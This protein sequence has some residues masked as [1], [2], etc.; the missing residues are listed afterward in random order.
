MAEVIKC[1]P[2]GLKQAAPAPKNRQVVALRARR[3]LKMTSPGFATENILPCDHANRRAA[4]GRAGQRDA[5]TTGC[6]KSRPENGNIASRT[7]GSSVVVALLIEV[8]RSAGIKSVWGISLHAD[9]TKSSRPRQSQATKLGTAQQRAPTQCP[10]GRC[11][12]RRP[13]FAKEAMSTRVKIL[14]H[15]ESS[16]THKPPS[17]RARMR[18]VFIF[19]EKSPAVHDD[20]RRSRSFQKKSPLNI[21]RVGRFCERTGR[22]LFWR[23]VAECGLKPAPVSPVMNRR[24]FA[25]NFGVDEHESVPH[26]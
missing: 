7:T 8:N 19:Y 17:R 14:R 23:A 6:P 21:M 22:F 11:C 13:K 16:P 26:P 10:V 20:F 12:R 24:N 2:L 18:W 9:E 5:R 25:R 15:H 4:P 1:F 3:W